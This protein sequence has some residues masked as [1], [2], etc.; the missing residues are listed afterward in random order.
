MRKL[1]NMTKKRE[2][3]PKVVTKILKMSGG[4]A[5]ALD[6]LALLAQ[7]HYL[8][9]HPNALAA[10]LPSV[11][12]VLRALVRYADTLTQQD[13]ITVEGFRIVEMCATRGGRWD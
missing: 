13:P 1:R 3:S 5:A 2:D 4:D 7:R 6:R 8:A 12:H 11:S 9:V 10:D